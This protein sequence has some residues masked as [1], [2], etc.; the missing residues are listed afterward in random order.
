[1]LLKYTPSNFFSSGIYQL[2]QRSFA[3]SGSSYALE[4]DVVKSESDEMEL[5]RF[6]MDSTERFSECSVDDT[7]RDWVGNMRS[8]CVRGRVMLDAAC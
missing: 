5:S 2:P 1:V 6:V 4:T 7:E 3:T 8:D